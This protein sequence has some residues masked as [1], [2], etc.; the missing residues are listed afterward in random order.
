MFAKIVLIRL[1]IVFCALLTKSPPFYISKF[2]LGNGSSTQP[3]E[4]WSLPSASARAA[5]DG[6]VAVGL[7]APHVP[8]LQG[9]GRHEKGE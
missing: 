5:E 7:H 4:A 1:K 3:L 8:G 6:H 2:S 9:Q